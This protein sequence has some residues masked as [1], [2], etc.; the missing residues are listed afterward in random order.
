MAWEL[1]DPHPLLQGNLL[2]LWGSDSGFLPTLPQACNYPLELYEV[3][4]AEAWNGNSFILGDCY[5]SALI[6]V[7]MSTH[8]D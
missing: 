5:L 4:G 6:S 3:S 1:G 8:M 7:F 2:L